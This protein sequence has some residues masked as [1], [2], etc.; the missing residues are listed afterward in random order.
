MVQNIKKGSN[1][2]NFLSQFCSCG[3]GA[4]GR[5]RYNVW[6]LYQEVELS[7]VRKLEFVDGAAKSVEYECSLLRKVIS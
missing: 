3:F 2:L 7:E 5:W 6:S 1:F 4:L